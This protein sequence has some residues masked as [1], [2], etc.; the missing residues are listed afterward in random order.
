MTWRKFGITPIMNFMW[1]TETALSPRANREK[2]T[3]IMFQTFNVPAMCVATQ[4]VLSIY[5]NGFITGKGCY[6]FFNY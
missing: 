4:A 2:M 6:P 5:S 3:E 1:L